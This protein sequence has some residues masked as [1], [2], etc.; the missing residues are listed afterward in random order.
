MD[1][2]FYRSNG[3]SA[4]LLSW[5]PTQFVKF[6]I[7]S[8]TSPWIQGMDK[9]HIVPTYRRHIY[10]YPWTSLV[11]FTLHAIFT[12]KLVTIM[13]VATT[14]HLRMSLHYHYQ[15]VKQHLGDD[16]TLYRIP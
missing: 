9:K 13:W 8:L 1:I 6:A 4:S 16:S 15:I 3:T 7:W 5:V 2:A 10:T 14:K 11:F 12:R